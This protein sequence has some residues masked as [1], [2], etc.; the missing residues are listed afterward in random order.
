MG[1]RLTETERAT[2]DYYTRAHAE[3]GSW[4]RTADAADAL[5]TTP[6]K[7]KNTRSRL[8]SKG[9]AVGVSGANSPGRTAC[10]GPTPAERRAMQAMLDLRAG[11][12]WPTT[13]EVAEHMGVT[14][15]CVMLWMRRLAEKGLAE[16]VPRKFYRLTEAAVQRRQS[17]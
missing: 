2:Y 15:R 12:W 3:T 14:R 16:R 6:C 13:A 4:P 17:A 8:R 7:L 1:E 10:E 11:A 5:G 9:Y